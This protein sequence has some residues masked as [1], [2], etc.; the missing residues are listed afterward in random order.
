MSLNPVLIWNAVRNNGILE[1][2]HAP[3]R[4]MG[5]GDEGLL[6]E[7]IRLFNLDHAAVS[8]LG[9]QPIRFASAELTELRGQLHDGL[10][11]Y[12]LLAMTP[13]NLKALVPGARLR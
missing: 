1:A 13:E 5:G 2:G 3:T 8:R 7:S 11:E 12:L 6:A 9:W 4:I 10:F